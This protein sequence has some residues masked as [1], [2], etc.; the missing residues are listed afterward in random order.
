M[1][2][3]AKTAWRDKQHS[4]VDALQE[5]VLADA[6]VRPSGDVKD[7]VLALGCA[8]DKLLGH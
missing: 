6:A 8:I 4:V 7:A 1:G 3:T 2:A 5:R